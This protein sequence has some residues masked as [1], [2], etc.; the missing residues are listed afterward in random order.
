MRINF[1]PFTCQW[2][3]KTLPVCLLAVLSMPAHSTWIDTPNVRD[4]L[5][6]GIFATVNPKITHTSNKFHYTLGDPKIYGDTG[7]M[8][9]VLADQDR[10]DAD[11]RLRADGV[12]DGFLQLATRQTLT[13]DLTL[14]GSVAVFY[15][16]EGHY[17]YGSLWGATLLVD[18]K[19]SMTVGD[20]WTRLPV[21]QTDAN[22]IIQNRGT[23][24][25]VEYT[26][27]PDLTLSAYHMFTASSDVN[28]PQVSGWHKSHGASAKYVFDLAP[29]N[30]LT[31]SLIHI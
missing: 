28:D 16:E 5:Q 27:I 23:N 9:Q 8:A 21:R 17:N 18:G 11:R 29:R 6:F 14:V 7:T 30:K 19:G 22:N 26:Q 1:S 2:L 10:Q 12:E 31:L 13:K 4:G 15:N 20:G 25:A 24:I 3:P